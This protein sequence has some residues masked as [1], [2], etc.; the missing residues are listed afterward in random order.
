MAENL[1]HTAAKYWHSLLFTPEV[2][3]PTAVKDTLKKFGVTEP[4]DDNVI[5]TIGNF[6][7]MLKHET[8]AQDEVDRIQYFHL[9]LTVYPPTFRQMYNAVT[10]DLKLY[11]DL[12]LGA[13]DRRGLVPVDGYDQTNDSMYSNT[14]LYRQRSTHINMTVH[15]PPL[16]YL[17][18]AETGRWRV[19]V[20]IGE[21]G[22]MAC[23]S[24]PCPTPVT[25]SQC[26]H[27]SDGIR[28]DQIAMMACTACLLDFGNERHFCDKHAQRRCG[29][30]G[31]G[32]FCVEHSNPKD[33]ACV[34]HIKTAIPHNYIILNRHAHCRIA[35]LETVPE[36]QF[37]ETWHRMSESER[38][39]IRS[40]AGPPGLED[41]S[42]TEVTKDLVIDTEYPTHGALRSTMYR[43]FRL[44]GCHSRW[45]DFVNDTV[46]GA[47][48]VDQLP[49]LYLDEETRTVTERLASSMLEATSQ[50]HDSFSQHY[51]RSRVPD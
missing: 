13:N 25:P 47:E 21:G 49:G 39:L 37:A 7:T 38:K 30:C 2:E 40:F 19:N 24:S 4:S 29:L 28:C 17:K 32:S 44:A 16:T 27:S 26:D 1:S 23:D 48:R 22:S 41:A 36:I 50:G 20:G 31:V 43:A 9:H 42:R 5:L 8:D 11:S 6:A 10:T 35:G 34:C 45:D 3:I 46:V 33:H 14:F 51:K 12:I 15:P 18:E